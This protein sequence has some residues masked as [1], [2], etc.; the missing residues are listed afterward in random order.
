M[1]KVVIVGAGFGGLEAAKA[2]RKASLDVT[3]IDKSN[4]H[5]F[6]PL[7][8]Q[9]ATAGLSPAD[10]AAPIRQVLRK[11]QNVK[12]VMA[13]VTGVDKQR[14][15]VLARNREFPYDFLVL[16]TGARHGYFGHD[17]WEKYAPGLKTI[18]DATRIRRNILTAFERAEIETESSARSAYL[19]FVIVGGGPTGVEV[20]GAIAEL[21]QKAL[22]TD[23]RHIDPGA[24]KIILVEA[25][26][27]IL[28]SFPEN[29]SQKA[30]VGLRRLGVEV[31]LN[32]RVEGVDAHGVFISGNRLESRTVIWAAGVKASPV[33]AWLNVPTDNSGR[34]KV[35]ENLSIFEHPEVFVIGD[36]ALAVV[37]GQA[38]PG[39]SP[40]AM[41]EGRYVAKRIQALNSG[42]SHVPFRYHDKGNLATVGRSFAVADLGRIQ[43]SGFVAWLA[44]LVVH[45]YYLIGFENRLL[46]FI[47]W[48][49]AYLTFQRGARLIVD[50][51]S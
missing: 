19:T 4:H 15:V 11:Q 42:K 2:F 30:L 29:L 49:W 13:E 14:R 50:E 9:V 37:E 34:V 43:I 6:Q 46:V 36:A 3:L 1:K 38:L 45:I 48:A 22:A 41:Q 44:W 17:D 32:T 35:D 40:V 39:V 51:E 10:I 8:Y 27:R 28:A 23:F 31:K 7:L 5:L 25:G 47:Q 12:V 24:A 18:K 21:A 20:A 33:G 26:A 16:A